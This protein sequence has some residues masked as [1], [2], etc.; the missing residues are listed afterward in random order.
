MIVTK[1][2]SE[3]GRPVG[4][5][6]GD[7]Q[8]LAR[9]KM[10][11]GQK[12][13]PLLGSDFITQSTHSSLPILDFDLTDIKEAEYLAFISHPPQILVCVCVCRGVGRWMP[14]IVQTCCGSSGMHPEQ[15]YH[16]A[17]V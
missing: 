3:M 2:A 10:G 4:V 17:A 7:S 1:G 13:K 5:H 14:G 9:Q 6:I 11:N 15:H 16:L 8:E 12:Q